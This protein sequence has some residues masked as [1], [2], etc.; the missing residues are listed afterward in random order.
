MS[1]FGWSYPAG[2]ASDPF[3]PWNEQELPGEYTTA[4]N[5]ARKLFKHF[6]ANT[7]GDVYRALYKGTDCGVSVSIAVEGAEKLFHGN[8][9]YKFDCNAPVCAVQI[10]SIVEGVDFDCA[11]LTL[12]LTQ[13]GT[14]KTG[15]IVKRLFA[16]VAEV[17]AEAKYIWQQTH[18][19][20]DC[21]IE[22]EWGHQA[23][24][25][26]CKTCKGFGWII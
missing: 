3:A 7:W 12:D 4:A 13:K 18:G 6:G 5:N 23:I 22:G 16:L 24:N 20:D 17:E 14:R 11:T 26:D 19:C 2:A 15:N 1:K 8:D 9:L 21:G 10:G 25:P